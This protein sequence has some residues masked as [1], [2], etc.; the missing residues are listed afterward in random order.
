MINVKKMLALFISLSLTFVFWG[1]NPSSDS[2]SGANTYIRAEVL[3][4]DHVALYSSST[5]LEQIPVLNLQDD[6]Y[7]RLHIG[8]GSRSV[9]YEYTTI[10]V[11][12]DEIVVQEITDRTGAIY[13]LKGMSA[14][15]NQK[16]E[17]EVVDS[18]PINTKIQCYIYI[19]FS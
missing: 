19:N 6:Y 5:E 17:I 15:E 2:G 8:P 7:L 14:C 10:T 9:L 12:G 11:F 1:C 16:I 18:I 3:D 13:T 4:S